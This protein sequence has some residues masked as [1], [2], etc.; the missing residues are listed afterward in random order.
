MKHSLKLLLVCL[1]IYVRPVILRADFPRIF[2]IA[3]GK[4]TDSIAKY[5]TDMT[6]LGLNFLPHEDPIDFT[7][8]TNL[9]LLRSIG[10]GGVNETD[11][12]GL[13]AY[14]RSM[15]CLRSLDIYG[16]HLSVLPEDLKTLMYLSYID[17]KSPLLE[18]FPS[19]LFRMPSIRFLR[20]R[21]SRDTQQLELHPDSLYPYFLS[22]YGHTKSEAKWLK[23]NH[24]LSVF[25]GE[26]ILGQDDSV[27]AVTDVHPAE[28]AEVLA[29]SE[30]LRQILGTIVA[31]ADTLTSYRGYVDAIPKYSLH[32]LAAGKCYRIRMFED[33]R[34]EVDGRILKLSIL[35]RRFEA[36]LELDKLLCP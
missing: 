33:E 28:F 20:F 10:V 14:V 6:I 7:C 34:I 2:D 17:I 8:L 15:P 13:I 24:H 4:L 19:V 32:A 21:G 23:D 9:H 29:R 26:E 16:E 27:D 18:S 12:R 3:P 22:D 36:A 1:V 30:H 31:C 25:S 5:P 35:F 11:L